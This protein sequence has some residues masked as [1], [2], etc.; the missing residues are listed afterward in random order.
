M[1]II[2]TILSKVDPVDLVSQYTEL[3]Q[4][5][6]GEYRGTCCVH[7]GENPMSLAVYSDGGIYCFSCGFAG[8]VIAFY[9][10]MEKI[11]FNDAV[12]KIAEINNIDIGKNQEWQKQKSH[13]EL[14]EQQARYFHSKVD[15]VTDYLKSRGLTDEII[16]LYQLGYCPD[17]GEDK[18]SFSKPEK[19]KGIS[20]ISIPLRDRNGRVIAFAYR[21]QTKAKYINSVNNDYYTKGDYLFNADKA[22]KLIQDRLYICEGYFDAISCEIQKIPCI[23]YSGSSLSKSQVGGIKEL[24]QHRENV[25][26]YLAP[27][28]DVV[29]L[30]SVERMRE[31]LK[32]LNMAVRVVEIN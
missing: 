24:C 26:L 13:T 27:D 32:I 29:G 12:E 3:H 17:L 16:N 31:R 30:E 21:T 22:R 11:S 5:Q 10:E 15:K 23:S 14:C 8:N 6:K 19:F 18:I 9:G 28:N 1:S 20:G 7:G 25:T 2:D 4:T